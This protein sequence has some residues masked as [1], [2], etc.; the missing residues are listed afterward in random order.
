MG[1]IAPTLLN[2]DHNISQF[3]CGISEL[4]NW[5]VKNAIKSQKRGM[6]RV[7][8]VT[9]TSTEQVVGYYAIAMGSVKRENAT[10][11]IRRNS[12][13]PIP[14]VVLARLGVQEDYHG[15]N[16][17]SGLLKDCVTRSVQAMNA[18][19]GAGTL[20]HA[21][22]ES[23]QSFYKKFGFTESH[24]DPLIL[25]ARICDIECSISSLCQK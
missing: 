18:V 23:A 17:G 19:G 22:D 16:I 15:M 11:A 5:L 24:I 10:S 6:A 21:I 14:M 2:L 20:V 4:D 25:M 12:P 7:Y 13:N 9:D 3:R 8:V 1:I